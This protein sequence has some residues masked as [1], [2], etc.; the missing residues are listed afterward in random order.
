MSRKLYTVYPVKAK[1]LL[2]Q[3]LRYVVYKREHGEITTTYY[4][5]KKN[6]ERNR[7]WVAG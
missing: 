4:G 3:G 1:H 5:T 2:K 7:N 6:A